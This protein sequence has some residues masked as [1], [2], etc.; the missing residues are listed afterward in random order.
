MVESTHLYYETNRPLS[1]QKNSNELARM[2]LRFN[3]LDQINSM[4]IELTGELNRLEQ[5]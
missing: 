2:G 1:S 4:N 5:E 3:Y